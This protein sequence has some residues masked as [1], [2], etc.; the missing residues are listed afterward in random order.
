VK[1]CLGDV[2]AA[3]V[4]GEL[5]HGA[6]ERAQRHLAHCAPCRAEVD[7]QRRLKAR[8]SGL[9]APVPALEQVLT[10]RL[11]RLAEPGADVLRTGPP[12]PSRP[13][14]PT[15]PRGVRPR[16]RPS[17]GVRPRGRRLLRRRTTAG[18]ALLA[19]GLTAAY[20][21][22][23]P[24]PQPPSTPLDPGTDAF[25]VEFISTTNESAP[26]RPASLT[27]GGVGSGR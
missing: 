10:T 17:T 9:T 11:L 18:T 1:D 4:D 2:V 26:A 13:A 16:S 22:G 12:E 25:V 19:L 6:R 14:G 27:T 3:L 24:Q 15:H 23:S 8:L 20:A 5:D 21:L 7:A